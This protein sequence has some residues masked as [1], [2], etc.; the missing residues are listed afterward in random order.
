M[1]EDDVVDITDPVISCQLTKDGPAWYDTFY[2]DDIWER[3]REPFV[4]IGNSENEL[5]ENF[6]SI[7]KCPTSKMQLLVFYACY[8]SLRTK[9]HR[10]AFAFINKKVQSLPIFLGFE[11]C[12]GTNKGCTNEDMVRWLRLLKDNKNIKAF[13]W[14][15]QKHCSLSTFFNS[16]QNNRQTQILLG[17]SLTPDTRTHAKN[18]MEVVKDEYLKN[19]KVYLKQGKKLHD[20]QSEE[21]LAFSDYFCKNV[22]IEDRI[23]HCIALQRDNQGNTYCYDPTVDHVM[24]NPTVEDVSYRITSLVKTMRFEIV[25][26]DEEVTFKIKCNFLLNC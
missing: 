12:H 8:N 13:Q 18:R 26:E 25:L 19:E 21:F 17:F 9:R 16:G 7:T 2:T 22:S 20:L 1:K 24:Y 5:L 23:P 10:L 6:D 4:Q 14:S 3:Y 15:K 11:D